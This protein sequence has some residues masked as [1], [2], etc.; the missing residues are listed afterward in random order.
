MTIR[1]TVPGDPVGKAR[2]RVTRYGTYNPEKTEAYEALAR[3]HLRDAMR[4]LEPL[5]GGVAV[6]IEA[7]YDIPKSYSK[8]RTVAIL[9]GDELPTKK[10]DA[11]NITKIILD[12]ANGI[13]WGDD[14]QVVCV[15]TVKRYKASQLA[16][17]C[18][19]VEIAELTAASKLK[20]ALKI[21]RKF[22]MGE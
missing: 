2:P 1:F 8:K 7:V 10:P 22:L 15:C 6:I 16:A 21:T 3:M 13:A 18:V 20:I 14:A 17:P 5:V 9:A 11:D 12:A 4:G 19:H